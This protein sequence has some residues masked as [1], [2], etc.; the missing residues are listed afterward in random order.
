MVLSM[1]ASGGMPRLHIYPLCHQLTMTKSKKKAN[2]DIDYD[3]R[4]QKA[5]DGVRSGIYK[6]SCH[7]A[8]LVCILPGRSEWR[9][10]CRFSIRALGVCKGVAICS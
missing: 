4:V 9:Q 8:T 7:A 3:D 5:A 2:A 10:G 1:D 6:S